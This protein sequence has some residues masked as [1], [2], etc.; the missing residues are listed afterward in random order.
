MKPLMTILLALVLTA[1][2]T[3]QTRFEPLTA[4]AAAIVARGD[5]CQLM[6]DTHNS[7][8]FYEQA[9]RLV[10]NDTVLYKLAQTNF[11]RG[12]Y[13]QC[14]ALTDT[15]LADTLTYQPLKLRYNCLQKMGADDS[16]RV[17]CARQIL[18]VNPM[19]AAVVTDIATYFN[20][21][22]QADSAIAYCNLYR[23]TDLTN[24][25]VNKQLGRALFIKKDYYPALDLFL[26]AYRNGD[27][28]PALLFYIGR[29]YECCSIP[30]RAHEFMQMAA[31][32]SNFA[33]LPIVKALARVSASYFKYRDDVPYYT[34][35]AFELCQADSASM[36]EVFDI[37]AR[38]YEAY[39]Y[40]YYDSDKLKFNT[41]IH[42]SIKMLKS[43]LQY[44]PSLTRQYNIAVAYGRM[45][46][47]DN[48][49]LW[50]QK[51][52]DSDQPRTKA[53][54]NIFEY[55]DYRLDKL[56]EDEFF[57]GGKKTDGGL[58]IVEVED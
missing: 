10:F 42:N 41:C 29:T 21:N 1:T 51:I 54:R 39:A 44:E 31:Y 18:A 26:D 55:A 48:E 19:D 16:L 46:D 58:E 15:L 4:E 47:R 6:N 5:S 49:R 36:A 12:Q 7:L 32:G 30:E 56:K 14:L 20:G 57:E 40:Q 3:A 2:A 13:N 34:Q 35:V 8:L 53:N 27:Q 11:R 22:Q 24:Q 38:F 43:A 37:K 25:L 45:H 17:E 23:R 33:S 50:L 52:K 28:T 9:R